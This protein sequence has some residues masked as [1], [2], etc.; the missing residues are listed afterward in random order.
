MGTRLETANS[1]RVRL[2]HK[3]IAEEVADLT[4]REDALALTIDEIQG[5]E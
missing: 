3:R 5:R 2:T 1:L 4:A